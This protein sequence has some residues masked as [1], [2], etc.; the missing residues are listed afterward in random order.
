[1]HQ[2]SDTVQTYAGLKPK[3][4]LSMPSHPNTYGRIDSLF[5]GKYKIFEHRKTRR[6]GK[7]IS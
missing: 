7:G 2:H 3:A 4:L 5:E 6:Q 1:M